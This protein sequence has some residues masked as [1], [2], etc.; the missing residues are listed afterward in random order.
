MVILRLKM[1]F[2]QTGIQ[3]KKNSFF[4]LKSAPFL[5]FKKGYIAPERGFITAE[6]GSIL[7]VKTW[8]FPILFRPFHILFLAAWS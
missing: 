6:K 8:F 4:E 3:P 1:A 5:H 2:F 7:A